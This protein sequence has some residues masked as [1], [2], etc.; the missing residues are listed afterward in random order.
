MKLDNQ[1]V[2]VLKNF[3]TINPNLVCKPGN[4]L[5]TISQSK[6]VM[7]KATVKT[8][9]N[10]GF[11]LYDLSRFLGTISMFK[12][13]D[14]DNKQTYM[15]ISE[16]NTKFKYTFCDPKLVLSPPE[17]DLNLPNCEIE[18]SLPDSALY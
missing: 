4:V 18:F 11:C 6:A 5:R 7:A 10:E 13:P 8:E 14:L 15:E 16:G 1:T 3:S 17:R 9:F 12:D 2:Q